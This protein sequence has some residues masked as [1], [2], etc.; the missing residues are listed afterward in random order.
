MLL[1]FCKRHPFDLGGKSGF[2]Q[3]ECKDRGSAKLINSEMEALSSQTDDTLKDK[4][5]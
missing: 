5:W 2:L 3:Q 4:L 1:L